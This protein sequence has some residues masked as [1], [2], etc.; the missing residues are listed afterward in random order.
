MKHIVTLT[1]RNKFEKEYF[2]GNASQCGEFKWKGDFKKATSFNVRPRC[3]KCEKV[4]G[5][6]CHC[7]DWVW[8]LT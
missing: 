3:I 1:F 2:M 4:I 8:E 5:A 7:K 6:G